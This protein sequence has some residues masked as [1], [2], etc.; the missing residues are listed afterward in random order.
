MIEKRPQPCMH[1]AGKHGRLGWRARCR[2]LPSGQRCGLPMQA[3]LRACRAYWSCWQARQTG[4]AGKEECSGLLAQELQPC[5][6]LK[7]G[8]VSHLWQ[9]SIFVI[10]CVVPHIGC[11]GMLCGPVVL[12]R[13]WHVLCK[14]ATRRV[15]ACIACLTQLCRNASSL[16]E[17]SN[18]SLYLAHAP[19]VLSFAG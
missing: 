2:M 13:W 15:A 7:H 8:I 19:S 9:F 1:G 4:R 12:E 6:C 18:W 10:M 17:C 5:T 16:L 11:R 3:Q 14:A